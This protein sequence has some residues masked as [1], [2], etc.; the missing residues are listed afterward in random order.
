[1]DRVRRARHGN[2]STV[3]RRAFLARLGR[4]TTTVGLGGFLGASALAACSSPGARSSSKRARRAFDSCP[5]PG[6]VAASDLVDVDTLWHWVEE[7]VGFGP[8]ITGSRAHR[9]Y[10]DF[11][12][13]QLESFGLRVTRSPVALDE[14]E[15]R[16]WS[17]EV[18]DAHHEHHT[19]PVAYYRPHSGET[20]AR[21][22]TAAVVDVGA[23][24]E[25]DYRGRDVQGRIV[26]VDWTIPNLT[27][28][29]WTTVADYV[30]PPDIAAQLA[31]EPFAR[32]WL[33]IPAPPSLEVAKEH[34]AVAMIEV[35]DMSAAN[36]HGQFSPHQQEHVGLPALHVDRVQ[37]ARLRELMQVG[38]LDATLV[39][40][41]SYGRSSIDYL[42]AEV[43]GSGAEPGSVLLM[44]HTDGQNAIEEN[45]GPALLA[46]ADYVTRLP[47]RCRPR[48]VTL[49]FS[50]NHMTAINSTVKPDTWLR[51]HPEVLGRSAM[52]LVA[53]H[54]GA[55][56]WDDDPDTGRYRSSGVSELVA[57]PVGN[58]DTLRRL[59]IDAVKA[60]DLRR[61]AV[62]R[63]REGG[64]YGEGTF[65]YRLGLPTIAFITG[66]SYLV[67]VTDGDDLDKLDRRLLHEQ[68]V[69]LARVLSRMLSLPSA[70]P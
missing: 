68:A 41:A 55:M 53:E 1:M 50:P 12:H 59:A 2:V 65:P 66:P 48:D 10:L 14:W 17:L 31:H 33:G 40:D 13:E 7:M 6:A 63:P 35:V 62:V 29:V 38:P 24:A 42:H 57:V 21:G 11:L 30:H 51:E 25:A 67:Q 15:A 37:G 45:G 39:L 60:A 54:L 36:A 34:G 43:P 9:S 56:A 52:A 64:L 44:T 61:A 49:L 4:A 16:A 22:V 70:R 19:I 28:A 69:F 18:V 20:P 8:R 3:D 23:G 5:V 47:R 32:I 58:S 46:L 26:L 27:A